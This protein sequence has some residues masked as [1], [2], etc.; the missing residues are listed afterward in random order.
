MSFSTIVIIVLLLII[1]TI[2]SFLYLLADV[3]S[4]KH[5]NKVVSFF[6]SIPVIIISK[7]FLKK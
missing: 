2:S 5:R 1:W 3:F 7:L 6:M 4:T